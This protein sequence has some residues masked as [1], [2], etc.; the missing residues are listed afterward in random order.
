MTTEI[1]LAETEAQREAVYKFRY[2]IYV[3]EMGRYRTI[4]DHD[5]G[6]LVEPCDAQSQLY[7]AASEGEVIG[8]LRL[9][10]GGDEALPEQ[11]IGE[12]GLAPFLAEIPHEQIIVGERFMIA[13]RWRGSDV[14][15][16]LFTAYLNFAN[17]KR[18]QLLFGD[19]EPHL[20]NAYLGLGFRTYSDHNIN[21]AETGYL[22]PLVMVPED[23][24]YMRRIG[25]PLVTVLKDFGDDTRLPD[26]IDR[27]LG[28]DTAVTSQRLADQSAYW[29]QIYRSLSALEESRISLFD[30]L[31][32]EQS[33]ACLDKSNIIDCQA[34]DRILKKG[35]VARNLFVLL[36]G[37]LEVRDDDGGLVAVLTPGEVFGEIAFL[38]GLART[39]DVYAAADDTRVLSL[40]ESTI[41]QLIDSDS[42]AAAKL[43]LNISKMLC[44]RLVR[45]G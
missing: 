38:L 33:Q 23:L 10:W 16:E 18:V 32:E 31:S 9:T 2:D 14:L 7:C 28:S 29:S 40:S 20:L 25:S 4:A 6:W 41:R 8:T 37:V 26:G 21:S 11:Q 17:E 34:G 22:I 39:R 13:P 44:R 43:L 5:R 12:Y 45:A 1:F 36:S 24:D 19:C 35:N 30:G 3:R 27:L 15:F 42:E